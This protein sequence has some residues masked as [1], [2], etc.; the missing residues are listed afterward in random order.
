MTAAAAF[1][2]ISYGPYMVVNGAIRQS[3]PCIQFSGDRP[4]EVSGR[5]AFADMHLSLCLPIAQAQT[6][7]KRESGLFP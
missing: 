3:P 6:Q 5:P 7:L 4:M 2:G 1:H